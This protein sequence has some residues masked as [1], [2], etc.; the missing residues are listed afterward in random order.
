MRD[1][2]KTFSKENQKQEGSHTLG[3]ANV[4]ATQS[5]RFYKCIECA[6]TNISATTFAGSCI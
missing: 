1:G 4:K 5:H 3:P 2:K 6:I